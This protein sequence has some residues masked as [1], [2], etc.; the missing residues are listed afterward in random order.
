M[1]YK[2]TFIG[3]F[4]GKVTSRRVILPKS[5]QEILSDNDETK[6]IVVTKGIDDCL[7][8]F[9]KMIYIENLSILEKGNKS[10][11]ALKMVLEMNAMSIQT[12]ESNGRFRISSELSTKL[13]LKTKVK[14]IGHSNYISVW[15]P[16]ETDTREQ[17]LIKFIKENSDN[18]SGPSRWF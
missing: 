10:D 16:K 8:I 5:F 15:L 18:D 1:N 3:S 4:E 11:V 13:N 12:L 17:D 6:S 7:L 2:G 9:P 14:F